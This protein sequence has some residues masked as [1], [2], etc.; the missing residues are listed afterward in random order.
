MTYEYYLDAI[1]VRGHLAGVS[2]RGLRTALLQS[3]IVPS[4]EEAVRAHRYEE[5]D[6]LFISWMTSPA[7]QE[8]FDQS[9]ELKRTQG[10]LREAAKTATTEEVRRRDAEA[11]AQA[12]R[13]II[14]QGMTTRVIINGTGD[15]LQVTI[16]SLYVNMLIVNRKWTEENLKDVT[17]H[18]VE[19][20]ALI[21]RLQGLKEKLSGGGS[22]IEGAERLLPYVNAALSFLRVAMGHQG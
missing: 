20:D 4:F 19:R 14:E 3:E 12:Y 13:D 18:A 5:A 9:V 22:L 17:T 8:K 2:E 1:A 16:G 15:D 10:L 21:T 11:K 6:S 7:M